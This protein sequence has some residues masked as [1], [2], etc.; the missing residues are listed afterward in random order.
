MTDTKLLSAAW[1]AIA[2]LR[3]YQYGNTSPELAEEVADVLERA[4]END[5]AGHEDLK[6]QFRETLRP[7]ARADK[8]AHQ[9]P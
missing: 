5:L 8:G 7:L 2:A 3:S 4:L 9:N 1:A 6:A